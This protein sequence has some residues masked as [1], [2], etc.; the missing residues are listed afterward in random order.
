MKNPTGETRRILDAVRDFVND[1]PWR[2]D[3]IV[4]IDSLRSAI[5]EPCVLA[6]TG[7]VKEGKSSFLNALLG[8]NLA[9]VGSTETTATI[10]IFKYGKPADPEK[11]VKVVWESGVSTFESPDFMDSLQG[12]DEETLKRAEGIRWLE[13]S[14]DDPILQDITLVDTPGTDAIVG[15]GGDAHQKIT[16]RFLKLRRKHQRETEELTSKAGAI[17]FLTGHVP[18]MTGQ[19]F[20]KDFREAG[21]GHSSSINVVGVISK[22]DFN[23]EVLKERESLAKDMSESL[24]H[25]LNAVVPV[26]AGLWIALQRLKTE[27]TLEKMRRELQSI[28][29]KAFRHMMDGEKNYLGNEALIAVFY[30][31]IEARPLSLECRKELRSDMQWSIFRAIAK[32]LYAYPLEEAVEKLTEISGMSRIREILDKHFFKRSPLLRSFEIVSKLERILLEIRMSKIGELRD[33]SIRL[34]DYERFI[35]GHRTAQN[36]E[37][38]DSLMTFVGKNLKT[39]KEIDE[40]EE[41]VINLKLQ[42]EKTKLYLQKTDEDFNNLQTVIKN[43]SDFTADEYEELTGLFGLRGDVEHDAAGVEYLRKRQKYWGAE[44]NNARNRC[45]EAAAERAVDVYQ[46]ILQKLE[47]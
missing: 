47:G 2:N 23:E 21:G 31:G 17:V 3:Y 22:I 45:R 18:R 34:N 30:K 9:R 1:S 32:H 28:P 12:R 20:L 16:D 8:K 5:D 24:K 26:S 35:T 4:R 40:L 44:Y 42:L 37:T 36:R 13:Y 7:R 39:K 27:N 38:A 11:P 25:E 19:N 6:V 10:N 33:D 15:E 43:K 29:E 41:Q 14:L 46:E